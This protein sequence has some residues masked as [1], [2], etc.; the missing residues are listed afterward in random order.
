MTV[1][2]LCWS[3]SFALE[4]KALVEEVFDL[5]TPKKGD[6]EDIVLEL[7]SP[8]LLN[9]QSEGAEN[10]PPSQHSFDLT[11]DQV[12]QSFE[13]IVNDAYLAAY[14]GHYEAADVLYRKAWKLDPENADI[15]FAIGYT[16]QRLGNNQIAKQ[17]Y[18]EVLKHDQ[19]YVKA[20]RNFFIIISKEDPSFAIAKL[21]EMVE[22]NP[23]HP[24]ILSELS[25]VYDQ[26]GNMQLA[27]K[28]ILKALEVD[29]ENAGFHCDAGILYEDMK[30]YETAKYHY[31][32]ALKYLSD[33][34]EC[35]KEVLKSKI[36]F[37]KKSS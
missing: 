3:S 22:A 35:D 10:F 4:D 28:Y 24:V 27:L 9:L 6:N 36:L 18:R 1:W 8:S 21:S 26:V 2:L 29:P 32:E 13:D 5:Y 34:P 23:L 19:Y 37:L 14:K 11:L 12:G 33:E 16:N 20:F 17:F 7:A 15:L 31:S 25:H 30:D